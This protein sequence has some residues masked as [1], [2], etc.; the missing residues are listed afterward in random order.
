MTIIDRIGKAAVYE[1]LAEECAELA[2]AAIKMSRYIRG[3][4]PP[5]KEPWEIVKS[6]TEEV[7]DVK[8]CLVCLG[9]EADEEIAERKF[10]RWHQRLD[11]RD[12]GGKSDEDL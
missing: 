12:F 5:A 4:N 8:I 6:L 10:A 7:T 3:E 11:E 9:I 2:Q 1:Q